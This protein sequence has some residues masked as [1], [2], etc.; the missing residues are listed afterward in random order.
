MELR[1]AHLQRD[2]IMRLYSGI[3]FSLSSNGGPG[4]TYYRPISSSRVTCHKGATK[5]YETLQ[6]DIELCKRITTNTIL[7]K[8][9]MFESLRRVLTGIIVTQV[10]VTSVNTY[11][12]LASLGILKLRHNYNVMMVNALCKYLATFKIYVPHFNNLYLSLSIST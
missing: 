2:R 12:L 7:R 6:R 5:D 3:S 9:S 8:F 10:R 4:L 1:L 11:T